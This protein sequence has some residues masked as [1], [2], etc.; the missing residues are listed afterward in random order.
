M[1]VSEDKVLK[2]TKDKINMQNKPKMGIGF[3]FKVGT[4]W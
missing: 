1:I 3:F 2:A 4:F